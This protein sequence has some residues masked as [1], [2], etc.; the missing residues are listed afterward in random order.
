MADHV[1]TAE[2]RYNTIRFSNG[3]GLVKTMVLEQKWVSKNRPDEWREIPQ[4]E[5]FEL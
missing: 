5:T 4:T 3:R 2:L 1:P